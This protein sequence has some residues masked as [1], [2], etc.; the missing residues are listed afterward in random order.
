MHKVSPVATTGVNDT[1]A[2]GDVSSQDLVEDVDVDLAE[3]LLELDGHGGFLSS[4][5][6]RW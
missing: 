4:Q 3:L 1:H 2:G 5:V 6:W